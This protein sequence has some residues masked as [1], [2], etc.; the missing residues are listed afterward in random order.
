[1]SQQ[2]ISSPEKAPDHRQVRALGEARGIDPAE[3][4]LDVPRLLPRHVPPE[5]IRDHRPHRLGSDA[6]GIDLAPAG[7]AAGGRDLHED[8]VPPAEARRRV[9][10]R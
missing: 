10:D 7:D 8:E 3:H 5:D 4:Q 9:A 1:M 6:R 2:A